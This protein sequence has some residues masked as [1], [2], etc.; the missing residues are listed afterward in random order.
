M[1]YWAKDGSYNRSEGEGERTTE[2]ERWERENIFNK[3]RAQ[4]EVDAAKREQQESEL[5]SQL[6]LEEI[7]LSKRKA[8]KEAEVRK[9]AED[10]MYENNPMMWLRNPRNL[11]ERRARANYW[12]K[13][14][15]FSIMM[16]K[17]SGKG[18]KFDKLW[19]QY[20]HAQTEEE[21]EMIVEQMEKMYP[22]TQARL[23]AAEREEGR[24]R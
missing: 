20:S 3:K 5:R 13:K 24:S 4:M 8:A 14:S 21:K 7:E 12:A 18:Q 1:G 22:T 6:R 2:A 15:T 9:A 11:D 17:I 19:D 10:K 16:D 23:D